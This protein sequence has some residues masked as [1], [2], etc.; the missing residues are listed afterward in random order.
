MTV[1]AVQ[2]REIRLQAGGC[3]EYCRLAPDEMYATFH[4][5]HIIPRKH[6]GL[7][8]NDN[9]CIACPDCNGYKGSDIATFDPLTGDLTPF[10]NP[11]EQ[12]WDEHFE[13][14]IDM[15][16]VGLT[17]EGRATIFLLQMNMQRRVIE[18]Y[19][20]WMR[21]EYPCENP[22]SESRQ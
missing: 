21:N 10:Y 8:F 15:T 13:L 7:D 17:P 4:I 2:S 14:E 3:C 19:E 18:R 6:G 20:A 1:T 16:I 12:D 22:N 11:R 9:L 5:D